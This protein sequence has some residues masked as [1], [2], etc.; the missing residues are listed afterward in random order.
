MFGFML[1]LSFLKENFV[2]MYC[3]LLLVEYTMN[4][5]ELVSGVKLSC[6]FFVDIVVLVFLVLYWVKLKTMSCHVGK[7][8]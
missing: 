6:F 3:A 1:L 8:V 5:G 2:N 4:T 7:E